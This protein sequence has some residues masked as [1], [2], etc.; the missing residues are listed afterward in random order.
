MPDD[1]NIEACSQIV[2]LTVEHESPTDRY[3]YINIF[4]VDPYYKECQMAFF[5]SSK[6]FKQNYND[7][8]CRDQ[9]IQNMIFN[10]ARNSKDCRFQVKLVTQYQES[11]TIS[12]LFNKSDEEIREDYHKEKKI[13]LNYSKQKINRHRMKMDKQSMIYYI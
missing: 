5:R 4:F 2:F 3:Y 13:N 10:T 12:S 1:L 8:D 6:V 7:I 9:I 11:F